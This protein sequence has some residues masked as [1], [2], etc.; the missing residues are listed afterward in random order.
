MPYEYLE[1]DA[2]IGIRAWGADYPQAL[3]DAV[4][5]LGGVMVG[6]VGVKAEKELQ[7]SLGR[8][9]NREEIS[10]HLDRPVSL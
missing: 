6:P 4:R 1:H 7:H 2:D 10:K 8:K 3:A 5:A 9:P